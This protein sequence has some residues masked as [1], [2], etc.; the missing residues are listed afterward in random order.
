MKTKWWI[1]L[2]AAAGAI[3][4]A[5][6]LLFPPPALSTR[7]GVFQDGELVREIDLAAV[8]APY[9][10]TISS[11]FGENVVQVEPGAVYMLSAD[12]PDG[13]CLRHAA[14]PG[15]VTP[16]VCLPHRLV[17]RTLAD[18]GAQ[19]DAVSGVAG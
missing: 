4:L 16:I 7:I 11:P 17:L 15:A 19:V 13:S 5:W 12:C 2:F 9:S 1:L 10:F 6:I 8:T 18:S 3:C 14:L